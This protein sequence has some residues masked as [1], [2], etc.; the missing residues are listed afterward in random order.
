MKQFFPSELKFVFSD[1]G[2]EHKSSTKQRKRKLFVSPEGIFYQH[3]SKINFRDNKNDNF[4]KFPFSK[5]TRGAL[6]CSSSD[7]NNKKKI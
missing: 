6:A 7:S 2:S 4:N 5:I 1:Q 3:E